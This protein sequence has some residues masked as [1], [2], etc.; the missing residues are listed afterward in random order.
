MNEFKFNES[1]SE[2]SQA[3]AQQANYKLKMII[4]IVI[5]II[6][7]ISV[8]FISNALFG[9]KEKK[10]PPVIG[11]NIDVED[12]RIVDLYAQVTYGM[13]GQRYEKYI[14]EQSV[15]L[16]N[17]TNYEK[18][19]YALKYA[20]KEDFKDTGKTE[21]GKKIYTISNGLIKKYMKKYFGEQ[22]TYSKN[23]SIPITFN[24]EIDGNNTGNLTYDLERA[25]YTI[26]F[27]SNNKNIENTQVIKPYYTTLDS[28][29]IKSDNSI[30]IKEKIIYTKHTVLKDASGQP[31][32]NYNCEIY[33]D[34]DRTMLIEQRL[35]INKASLEQKPI[36]PTDY[37]KLASTIVY[38]FKKNY[39]G[40]YYFYSSKIE[41]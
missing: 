22:V 41:D 30:E 39:N 26:T 28:A 20:K 27:I 9:K 1:L 25:G 2:E 37:E 24:F 10:E 14:K 33:K 4:I 7:G 15:K 38:T 17:F 18:F 40:D 12:D 23:G 21:N 3:K 8:F 13:R 6:V 11:Q 34:Y 36:T 29:S 31:I 16:E 5:S 19:Y 32:D 35:S